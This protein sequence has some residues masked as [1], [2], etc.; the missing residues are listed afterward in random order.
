MQDDSFSKNQIL[1]LWFC[2]DLLD[3]K[4]PLLYLVFSLTLVS[5]LLSK[6]FGASSCGSCKLQKCFEPSEL[7]CI[8]LCAVIFSIYHEDNS[9]NTPCYLDCVLSCFDKFIITK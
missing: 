3:D 1:K 9:H 6:D 7:G 4:E 8:L 5:L 2:F